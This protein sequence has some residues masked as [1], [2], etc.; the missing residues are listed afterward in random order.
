[1]ATATVAAAATLRDVVGCCHPPRRHE[2]HRRGAE[3]GRPLGVPHA[4]AHRRLRDHSARRADKKRSL[5]S[6]RPTGRDA[7][8]RDAY[9]V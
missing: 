6:R 5:T 7:S 9:T 8:R 2:V 1:M 3:Q 4:E